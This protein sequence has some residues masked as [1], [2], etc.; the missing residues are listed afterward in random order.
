MSF[1]LVGNGRI[2]DTVATLI[3]SGRFPH[4]VIIEGEAGLGKRTLARYLAKVAVCENDL[5]PCG[6]CRS[7]H[8]ADTMTHPDI[9]AIRPEDK[10]KSVTVDQIREFRTTAYHSAHTAKRRAFI[11]ESA[12]TMNPASQNSLLKVLEE[13]P[14]DVIFILVAVNSEALLDTV[15]SRC[16]TLSLS[17]PTLDE[18]AEFLMKE[19]GVDKET[20]ERFLTEERN[21]VGRALQRINGKSESA[22]K[23]AAHDFLA[24]IE[25]GSALSA[26]VVTA[27][28][29]KDRPEAEKFTLE[30]MDLLAEKLKANHK[31]TET[32]REYAAMYREVS[33]LKPTLIRNINLSLYFAAL[34][35]KL[36]AVR[37]KA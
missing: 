28:L 31:K 24:A 18:G 14:S 35:S 11:I 27:P 8:L 20:A 6:K 12:D 30:L 26:L 34:V 23:A 4:A 15:I 32:A 29:E 22:G 7:C 19:Q 13:P 1:P 16:L 37:N 36:C 5:P 2:K 33:K 17:A 21:N 25:R 10:K 9:E 3:S